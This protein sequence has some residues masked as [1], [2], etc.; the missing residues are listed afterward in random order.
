MLID[1]EINDILKEEVDKL[2][3]DMK[4]RNGSGELSNSI[5]AEYSNDG[6]V[7][8]LMDDYGVF[9]DKGVTGNNDPN[10]KGKRKVIHKSQD[11]YK[12]KSKVIGGEKKIDKW[13][14]KKGIQGRDKKGRFIKRAS[15]N[16][17]IRRSIAQHGIKG[18][19]FA[20]KAFETFNEELTERLSNIDFKNIIKH[21]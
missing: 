17:L 9:I 1:N 3:A 10:F 8:I 20:S 6:G 15:T 12:F 5:K 13:M 16:F 4:K 21:N 14:S 11:N 19:L 2:V 7:E 18:T